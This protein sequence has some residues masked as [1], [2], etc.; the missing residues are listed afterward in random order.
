MK[1]KKRIIEVFAL[2]LALSVSSVVYA[3]ESV[4]PSEDTVAIKATYSE[5][6][7]TTDTVYYVDVAWGSLEYFYHSGA[8]RT[9]DTENLIFIETP[10]EAKWS[11]DEGADKI[12][13]TNHSNTGITASF[14]Y[15]ETNGSGIS[16]SFDKTLLSLDSPVEGSEQA[17]APSGEV[18]LSLNG[19]LSDETSANT[20]VGEVTVSIKGGKVAAIGTVATMKNPS[21][22]DIEIYETETE[23][24]Y[25]AVYNGIANTTMRVYFIINGVTYS[26]VTGGVLDSTVTANF[27]I[28]CL[29]GQTYE[30]TF[31]ISDP[32]N[33]TWSVITITS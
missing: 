3:E 26:T 22:N 8:T 32:T 4:V 19:T 31:D 10:G 12:T 25:T 2:S 5:E 24:I 23:G 33:P 11:C 18:Q 30:F 15:T 29:N 20:V 27:P 14:T 7:T 17:Q 28:K 1:R 21:G 16:G 6:A 13:V 9:W